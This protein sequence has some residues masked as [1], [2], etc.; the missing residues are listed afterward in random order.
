VGDL[1]R[2]QGA[3]SWPTL[4]GEGK[5]ATDPV[6]PEGRLLPVG[7][8]DLL[9]LVKFEVQAARVQAA[10]MVTPNSWSCTGGSAP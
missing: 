4:A 8:A 5:S 10:R 9:E 2:R 7:Y 1:A 6:V 3:R